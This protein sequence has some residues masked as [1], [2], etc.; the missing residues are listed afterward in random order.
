MTTLVGLLENSEIT[1]LNVL[2]ARETIAS[3]TML[4]TLFL[5]QPGKE[6]WRKLKLNIV[7]GA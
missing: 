5:N 1:S 7:F 6:K 2:T 3:I 4:H